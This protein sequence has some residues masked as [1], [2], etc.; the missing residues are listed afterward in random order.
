MS[1]NLE[2]GVADVILAT[3]V[4]LDVVHC[5]YERQPLDSREVEAEDSSL[6]SER[7]P[8]IA[9]SRVGCGICHPW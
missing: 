2:F 1:W 8:Y 4:D 6:L 5:R 3:S 9:H 7:L